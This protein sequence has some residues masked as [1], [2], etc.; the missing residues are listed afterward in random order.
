M[1]SALNRTTEQKICVC[2]TSLRD[3]STFRRLRRSRGSLEGC[4]EVTHHVA[5]VQ[6]R[7]GLRTRLMSRRRRRW[8]MTRSRQSSRAV[9]G[10]TFWRYFRQFGL[11][12]RQRRTHLGSEI[13]EINRRSNTEML[14][15]RNVRDV[16]HTGA[17]RRAPSSDLS[18]IFHVAST[19]K[20]SKL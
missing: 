20:V 9:R 17:S 10:L 15:S 16:N 18:R 14:R 1:F 7:R 8:R 2:L 6:D 4:F 13:K 12:A 11:Y 5:E 3:R 19:V